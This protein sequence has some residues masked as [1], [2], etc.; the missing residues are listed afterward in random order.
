MKRD[1]RKLFR[2]F[3]HGASGRWTARCARIVGPRDCRGDGDSGRR[4]LRGQG[5]PEQRWQGQLDH[6][7]G[8]GMGYE[9]AWAV[10]FI[11]SVQMIVHLQAQLELDQKEERED[12]GTEHGGESTKV[13]CAWAGTCS[14][15]ASCEAFPPAALPQRSSADSQYPQQPT[16]D[17]NPSNRLP[18]AE[19]LVR[20]L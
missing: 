16:L 11:G 20:D 13:E 3:R 2:K 19:P 12:Q 5:G 4:E 8:G 18:C 6:G 10:P 17:A 1:R 9:V 14:T 7:L 15:Q